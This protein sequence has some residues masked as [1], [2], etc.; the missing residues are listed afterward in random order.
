VERGR[1]GSG[2]LSGLTL[3]GVGDECLELLDRPGF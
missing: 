2:N 1:D 3:L